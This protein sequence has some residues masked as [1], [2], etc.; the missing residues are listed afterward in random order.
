MRLC[1]ASDH[2]AGL[3]VVVHPDEK[4]ILAISRDENVWDWGFPGGGAESDVDDDVEDTARRE[5][6]E[7][8]GVDAGVLIP[9][10]R[11]QSDTH[12]TTTFM[13]ETIYS[14]PAV[15]RSDPFE[16][17]VAWV[18]TQILLAPTSR[19]REHTTEILQLMG[20]IR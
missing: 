18:E 15:L 9:I 14:W 11:R 1:D 6:F 8:T 19:Y 3:V 16:G 4:R 5:L 12:C 10:H 13:A 7:E 20:L 2:H 17:Y